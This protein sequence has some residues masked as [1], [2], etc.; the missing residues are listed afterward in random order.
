[1]GFGFVLSKAEGGH[2]I[3]GLGHQPYHRKSPN[4]RVTRV[5]IVR[6][7]PISDQTSHQ[8]EDHAKPDTA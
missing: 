4:R 6:S 1:M 8:E 7:L 3:S 5:W 2:G